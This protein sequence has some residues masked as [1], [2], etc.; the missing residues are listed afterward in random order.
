MHKIQKYKNTS[1]IK[2]AKFISD[3]SDCSNTDQT[4]H[5]TESVETFAA[6]I[7]C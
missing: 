4:Q 2:T 7:S 5:F 6:Q 3:S 1:K